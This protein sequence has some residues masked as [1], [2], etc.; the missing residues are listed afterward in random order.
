[1]VAE[2]PSP[3]ACCLDLKADGTAIATEVRI[4]CCVSA[5]CNPTVGGGQQL[6]VHAQCACD[7][8]V[9]V[10]GITSMLFALQEQRGH[11]VRL[12]LPRLW[13]WA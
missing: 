2:E 11:P 7:L 1:M 13:A 9:C 4:K 3:A 5:S 8:H 12:L 10:Y 6:K